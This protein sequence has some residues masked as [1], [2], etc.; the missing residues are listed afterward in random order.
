M[1]KPFRVDLSGKPR[2][3]LVVLL[4]GWPDDGH[5]WDELV[6]A[7]DGDYRFARITLP[8]FDGSKEEGEDFS[9]WVARL[10][11]TIANL[12][13]E[14][15][16]VLIA[17][18]WG[19]WLAYLYEREHA[20]E[21]AAMV[22]MD[23]GGHAAPSGLGH[24]LFVLG[25]Q[26]WLVAAYF[27]GHAAPVVG[28]GM[29][30]AIARMARAPRA[31][32][33][34]YRMNYPYFYFWR[35]MFNSRYQSSLLKGYVPRVPVLYLYGKKK[36]YHFH[37]AKWEALL[38]KDNRSAVVEM[39]DSGH[40]VM[41]DEFLETKRAIEKWLSGLGLAKQPRGPEREPELS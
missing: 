7:L 1:P 35:A 33:T 21:I 38:R 10:N 16:I 5:L 39:T 2:G 25:Y 31:S 40:W 17:H 22:T 12:K 4:H 36:P 15:K 23:V 24:T 27:I 29:S 37:S 19:A 18:D 41:R 30:R 14:N 11:S 20:D 8:A 9:T 28:N 26:W 6:G 3:R 32:Q 13:P 34:S